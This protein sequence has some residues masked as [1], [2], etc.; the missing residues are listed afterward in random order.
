MRVGD[1]GWRAWEEGEPVLFD[2]S[3]EHEVHVI[4]VLLSDEK[5]CS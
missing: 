4:L 5:T 3:F 1:A 2:D